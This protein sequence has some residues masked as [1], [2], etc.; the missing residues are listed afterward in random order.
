A[1][2]VIGLLVSMKL[3]LVQNFLAIAVA[4]VIGGVAVALIKH[5]SSG[6]L[7]P[8]TNQGNVRVTQT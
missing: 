8:T 6:T 4:A 1:P 5:K 3:P 2:I 7:R